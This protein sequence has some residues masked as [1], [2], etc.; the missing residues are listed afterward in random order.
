MPL[1]RIDLNKRASPELVRTVCDAVYNAMVEIANVPLHDRF[2]IVTRHGD[3]EI[4]YPPEGYLGVRYSSDVI[5]I[6]ITW[7]AG[8]SIEVKQKFYHRIVDEIH[9]K[10]RVRKEDVVI[11]LVD[12]A[13]EDWSFGNGVM[14]YAPKG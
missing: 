8:R 13:R 6:Q 3:D 2:Q 10:Q 1:A 9:D 4:L 14:Q 7:V 5:I 12:N 11:V